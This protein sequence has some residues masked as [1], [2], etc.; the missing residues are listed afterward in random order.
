MRVQLIPMWVDSPPSEVPRV[1]NGTFSLQG[2]TLALQ[3]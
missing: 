2:Q 1:F 3:C